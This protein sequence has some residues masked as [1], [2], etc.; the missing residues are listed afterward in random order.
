MDIVENKELGLVKKRDGNKVVL[1][2]KKH[3]FSPIF[4]AP[5]FRFVF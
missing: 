1:V 3:T 2:W 4:N 5:N